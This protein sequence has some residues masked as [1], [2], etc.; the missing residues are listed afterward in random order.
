MS[1]G[2]QAEACPTQRQ[3]PASG[4][5]PLRVEVLWG[6]DFSRKSIPEAVYAVDGSNRRRETFFNNTRHA[7]AFGHAHPGGLLI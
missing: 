7:E 4:K 1:N 6:C 5:I 2:S 3:L